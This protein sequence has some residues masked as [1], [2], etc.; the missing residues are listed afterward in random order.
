MIGHAWMRAIQRC[1]FERKIERERDNERGWW[2]GMLMAHGG[3]I[4]A[5]GWDASVCVGFDDQEVGVP[6]PHNSARV[7]A[8]FT[9]AGGPRSDPVAFASSRVMSSRMKMSALTHREPT[10]K[11]TN[12][13]V[14]ARGYNKSSACM[15]VSRSWGCGAREDAWAAR[16]CVSS[17]VRPTRSRATFGALPPSFR[18]PSLPR[19]LPIDSI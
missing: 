9:L 15:C 16:A 11:D 10:W 13:S 5:L 3:S 12:A 19:V 1:V 6:A 18:A 2:R 8:C 17:C 7:R 14:R 4:T